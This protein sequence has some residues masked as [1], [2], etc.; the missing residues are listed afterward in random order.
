MSNYCNLC[1][2]LFLQEVQQDPDCLLFPGSQQG[3]RF[4][5][6]W[7]YQ[8][9][10]NKED[11]EGYKV[12]DIGTHNTRKGATTY[13]ASGSTVSPSSV[14]MSNCGD[15]TLG[16]IQDVI[17]L[18][19]KVGD[20]YV[21]GFL[22]GLPVLSSHFAVSEPNFWTLESLDY[23]SARKQVEINTKV[24][25]IL[26]SLFCDIL[27]QQVTVL[28]LLHV[29]LVYDLR[30]NN[31]INFACQDGHSILRLT[32]VFK[33]SDFV[34][35][36]QHVSIRV[37]F[38]EDNNAVMLCGYSPHVAPLAANSGLKVDLTKLH[39]VF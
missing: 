17:M 3:E 26:H 35:I 14:A 1:I 31:G 23:D 18:Y 32:A 15:W 27:Y 39:Q 24:L 13:A 2:S 12:E 25:T 10:E 29:S 16:T 6:I 20:G 34:D 11:L 9:N 28:P 19:E 30:Y 7:R 37:P 21:G 4:R 22:A 38:D 5:S 33:S 36:K 8:L